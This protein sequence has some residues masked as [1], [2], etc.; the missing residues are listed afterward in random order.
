[1]TELSDVEDLGPCC[2][3]GTTEHV[4]NIVLLD[5]RGPVAGKG[6]GCVVCSLPCDGAV[7]VLCD[8]CAGLGFSPRFVCE[9]Y[10]AERKRFSTDRLSPEPFVHKDI[11]H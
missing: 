4:V 7:A 9:G 11:P 10:P 5:Q 8:D 2:N 3:C 6:W 1:V